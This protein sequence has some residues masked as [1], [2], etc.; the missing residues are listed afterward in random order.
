MT[1]G[2]EPLG[3]R[4]EDGEFKGET[5]IAYFTHAGMYVENFIKKSPVTVLAERF[6]I[7][8]VDTVL[9]ELLIAVADRFEIFGQ[10]NIEIGKEVSEKHVTLLICLNKTDLDWMK[11]A[12]QVF[13]NVVF[14][15]AADFTTNRFYS[16][17]H[18][19]EL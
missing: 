15:H 1:V 13:G 11:K 4:L 9:Q 10:G 5:G 17:V 18:R 19:A 6:D 12:V 8:K 7:V 16:K 14:S 3:I 2:N